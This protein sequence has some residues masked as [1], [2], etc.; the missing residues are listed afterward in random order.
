MAEPANTALGC[1][2]QDVGLASCVAELLIGHMVKPAY[3]LDGS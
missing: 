1:K 3:T 2:A